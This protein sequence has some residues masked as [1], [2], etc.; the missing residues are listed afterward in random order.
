MYLNVLVWTH[1]I[2][3]WEIQF[4]LEDPSLGFSRLI[5]FAFFDSRKEKEERTYS[6]DI[7]LLIKY[8]SIVKVIVPKLYLLDAA[9]EKKSTAKKKSGH[10]RIFLLCFFVFCKGYQRKE[11]K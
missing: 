3:L 10:I 7:S 8:N 2:H 5:F 6:L 4:V 11:K 9:A 1:A